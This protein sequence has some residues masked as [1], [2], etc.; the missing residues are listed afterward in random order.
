MD[1]HRAKGE[2]TCEKVRQF[3]PG[4]GINCGS[5]LWNQI[6]IERDK[7]S[8]IKAIGAFQKHGR[9]ISPN[10]HSPAIP[11]PGED[12]FEPSDP[13]GI[14]FEDEESFHWVPV[15]TITLGNHFRCDEELDI[16]ANSL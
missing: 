10:L 2:V 6:V 7:R 14:I 4:A 5:R 15:I 12:S 11:Q 3:H 9:R 16:P 13:F 8:L 1:D